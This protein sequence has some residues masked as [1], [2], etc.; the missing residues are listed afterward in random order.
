MPVFVLDD[1]LLHGRFASAP[2]TQCMLDCLRSLHEELEARGSGLVVRAGRPEQL[3]VK[4]AREV[5]AG[6]VLWTSDVAPYARGRDGR[7]TEALAQEGIRA[8]PH[9]GNYVVDVSEPRPQEGDVFHVFSRFFRAWRGMDRREVRGAPTALP[10]LPTGLSK[11]H[12]P[13]SVGELG[14]RDANLVPEP[15][16][17]PDYASAREAARRWLEGPVEHYA[18]RHDG[19]A[20]RGTS[21]LSPY[22][23]WGCLSSRE[24]EQR[25]RDKG[26]KGAAAWA[27]QL[28]WRDFYAHVL[29]KRPQNMTLELKEEMRELEYADSEDHL[30][31]WQRGETGYPGVDAGMRQLACT[32]WMHN[33]ARLIVGSFLAKDLH[34][35]W[36]E[37]ERWFERL[38]LD[39]EPAQNNGNWQWI[40]SV[41]TDP[42]PAFRR[43]YNPTLQI[44]RLD[45]T[46]EYVRRWV[47]ELRHVPHEKLFEPWTMGER[48]QR[49]AGCR[50]G[51]D[52][53]API[54][55]HQR[56]RKRALERYADAV[57]ED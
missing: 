19:M 39:G 9:G 45:L 53:P 4:L 33:R 49:D 18:D 1:A 57:R 36:R 42:A 43:M 21:L 11:G 48:E 55:D 23:R 35:D 47:P 7:V 46:G 24:L 52:Y 28:G 25:A 41:G 44:R 30:L 37:G 17:K 51:R 54:V 27:R 50:I 3:L 38:L 40:A 31:S 32:G 16:A 6:A 22:L 8:R 15:V 34:L 5:G 56:E 2:R 10:S 13:R 12:L 26:G 14:L 20:R 29:L